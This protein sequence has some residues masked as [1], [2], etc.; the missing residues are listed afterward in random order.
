MQ[1]FNTAS[2]VANSDMALDVPGE[3]TLFEFH[4]FH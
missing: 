3:D 1:T 4:T 2:A